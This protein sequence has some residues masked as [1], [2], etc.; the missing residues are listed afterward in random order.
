[1]LYQFFKRLFRK[2]NHELKLIWENPIK[3]IIE[4]SLPKGK[5]LETEEKWLDELDTLVQIV[6]KNRLKYVAV[7][8]NFRTIL[9][10]NGYPNVAWDYNTWPANHFDIGLFGGM[11]YSISDRWKLFETAS[12]PAQRLAHVHYSYKDKPIFVDIGMD[13]YDKLLEEIGLD[14]IPDGCKPH[15]LFKL[16]EEDLKKI[17]ERYL[18]TCEPSA[19]II[20]FQKQK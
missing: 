4:Y 20:L 18:Y 12:L 13:Q 14:I 7:I 6:E 2:R 8:H 19:E 1:M 5:P 3:P 9:P 16:M 10:I 15:D 17:G 11:F